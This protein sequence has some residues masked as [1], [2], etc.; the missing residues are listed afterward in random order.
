[1]KINIKNMV[2]PRCIIMMR[3]VF[4]KLNLPVISIDLG[5]VELAT[6]LTNIQ[7]KELELD[8]NNLGFELIEEAK[9]LTVEKI[10]NLIVDL[11]QNENIQLKVKLSAYSSSALLQD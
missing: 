2:C 10:K 6:I 5:V 1:M 3:S 9:L 8:L 4:E 11:V 7:K